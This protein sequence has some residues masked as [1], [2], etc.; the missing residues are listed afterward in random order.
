M[1]ARL[2]LAAIALIAA[3]ALCNSIASGQVESSRIPL[4]VDV[5][6]DGVLKPWRESNVATAETGL[7]SKLFVKLGDKVESGQPLAVLDC[8]GLL[9]QL[10]MAEAQAAS[11]GRIRVAEAEVE[12]ARLKLKSIQQMIDK[13]QASH[14]EVLK[15]QAD[16]QMAQGRLETEQNEQSVSALQVE[17]LKR[18]LHERTIYAPMS[19]VVVQLH[20][21]VGEYVAANS[22]QV[23]RVAD[24]SKLKAS[25]F[26]MDYELRKL[27][28]GTSV[29]VK[30]SNNVTTPAMVD[31]VAPVADGE[32]GLLEIR[33]SISNPASGILGSRCTLLLNGPEK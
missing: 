9:I 14:S 10:R 23:V 24:V 27:S 16:L 8:E 2:A 11:M 3:S 15:I 28:V 5:A 33:V 1:N 26:L 7:V 13:D 32:S 25:F 30:L 4:S 21:E 31:Y 17:K 18:Q 19:G 20:K 29:N 6:P 22:P 12:F